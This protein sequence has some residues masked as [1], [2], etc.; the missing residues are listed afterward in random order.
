MLCAV[1]SSGCLPQAAPAITCHFTPTF[2]IHGCDGCRYNGSG[3][4]ARVSARHNAVPAVE[5]K[6]CAGSGV[7]GIPE[8]SPGNDAQERR[9]PE[10]DPDGPTSD[11]SG[12]SS[13]LGAMVLAPPKEAFLH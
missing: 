7:N 1:A 2:L 5:L 13:R 4:R 11:R 8:A 10:G 3:G 12:M 9:P 6:E